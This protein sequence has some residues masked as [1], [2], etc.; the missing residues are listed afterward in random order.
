[1]R[2]CLHFKESDVFGKNKKMQMK[3][4]S[5]IGP[6]TVITGKLIF[7]GNL[8]IEG[9][10]DGNVCALADQSGTLVV[11]ERARIHGEV[12]V[13]HLVVDGTV[14]GQVTSSETIMLRAGARVTGNVFYRRIDTHRKSLLEGRLVYR[15]I[16]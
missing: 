14:D 12:Q 5:V 6:G 13:A 15:P 4:D 10:V 2:E 11:S 16:D 3:P 1:L 7:S 9:T 8:Y